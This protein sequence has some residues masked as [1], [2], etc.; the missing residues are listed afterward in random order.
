M[1]AGL[2]LM[3]IPGLGPVLAAGPLAVALTGAITG[4]ALGGFT[5]SLIGEGVSEV[6]AKAAERQM[7]A[8]RT[9][10]IL[11]CAGPCEA[12]LNI[13][14]AKGWVAAATDRPDAGETG[15]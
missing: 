13:L 4:G 1:L 8:G 3:G 12:A 5:G 6:E 15:A 10:V 14:R 11:R 7:K 2:G 9:V